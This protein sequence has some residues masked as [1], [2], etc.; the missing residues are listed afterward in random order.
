MHITFNGESTSGLR[1]HRA[2]WSSHLTKAPGSNPSANAVL[3]FFANSRR[4]HLL[5]ALN[6]GYSSGK[7]YTVFPLS[8]F[9]PD[10]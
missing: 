4:L 9:V 10:L 2:L 5:V 3:F 6:K 7:W 8:C 1:G